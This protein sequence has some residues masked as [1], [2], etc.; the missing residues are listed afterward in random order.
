MDDEQHIPDDRLQIRLMIAG[1]A[2]VW[3]GAVA[4]AVTALT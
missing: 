4:A 1:V 3:I 2:A